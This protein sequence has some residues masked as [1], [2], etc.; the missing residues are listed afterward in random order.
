MNFFKFIREKHPN[1]LVLFI[2]FIVLFASMSILSP[3]LF[4]SGANIQNMMAQM[5][6]FGLMALAMMAAILT[7]GM[8][9][10][11]ISAAMLSSIIA[12]SIMT[13]GFGIA[14]PVPATIIG[15]VVMLLFSLCTGVLNGILIGYIG[16][17]A[18]LVTLGTRMVFDG[19]GLIITKGNSISGLP[20]PFL[21]IGA[22]KVG[23]IPVPMLL[24][25]LM[26]IVSYF[27]LERSKW[28]REVY[29]IGDNEV[30]T[31]FSGI[32]TKKVIMLVYVFSGLLYG[33]SGILITSRYCSAKTDYGSSYLMQSLT[34]VVMG[35]TDINGGRGTVAGTVLAILILQTIS[36][37]FT[38]Y[39]VDQNLVNIF[40]GAI[41]ILVL[42]IR[43]ITGRVIDNK[44]IKA[45]R[46]AAAAQQ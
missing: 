16:I 35:G 32:N 18:M 40:S 14:N 24:F 1:E 21:A 5:P 3:D 26:I 45:R 17:V 2:I 19:I 13:S 25:V 31:R 29:M 10:S 27:V 43:Y 37:G 23:P 28:G 9:L 11:I 30:A 7:G 20:A 36:N 4:L 34:A 42:S 15:V 41:L 39:R 44:K 12:S 46:A 33:L 6:E 22:A 8:N 38:I